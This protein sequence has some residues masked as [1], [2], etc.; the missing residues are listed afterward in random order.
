MKNEKARQTRKRASQR[1]RIGPAVRYRTNGPGQS[2]RLNG[3]TFPG[4]ALESL[5][6]EIKDAQAGYRARHDEDDEGTT[7]GVPST[8][9]I[10]ET[11]LDKLEQLRIIGGGPRKLGLLDRAPLRSFSRRQRQFAKAALRLAWEAERADRARRNS[12]EARL[13]IERRTARGIGF[14]S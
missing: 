11:G 6:W 8:F 5:W 4:D 10:T 12:D 3:A 13:R 9:P 1:L 7:H 14:G 2:A